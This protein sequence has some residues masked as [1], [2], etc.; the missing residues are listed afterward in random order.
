MFS[1]KYKTY[2]L[3]SVLFAAFLGG[4]FMLAGCSD[5]TVTPTGTVSNPNVASYDS[6]AINETFDST[7]FSGMNILLGKTVLRDDPTKDVQL[8]D[9]GA[10]IDFYLRSGDMS[11]DHIGVATR[12]ALMYNDLTDLQFDTISVYAAGHDSLTASDFTSDDSRI[13]TPPVFNTPLT[14]HPVY[15]VWLK[16]KHDN[17]TTVFNDYAIIQPREMTTS[18]SQGTRM[19]WRIRVNTAGRNDFRKFIPAS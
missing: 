4:V 9:N 6:V 8:V 17:G 16:G 18:L 15:C 19:S 14:T 1:S 2:S 12:F 10:G 7:S 3:F 11:V 13:S 5:D